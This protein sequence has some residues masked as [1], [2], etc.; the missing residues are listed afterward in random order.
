MKATTTPVSSSAGAQQPRQ[1]VG[2][3]HQDRA[4][5]QA[6][7][8]LPAQVG[9]ASRAP[10]GT[11]SPTKAIGPQPRRRRPAPP[12]TAGRPAGGG[13]RTAGRAPCRRPAPAGSAAAPAGQQQASGDMGRRGG[14]QGNGRPA[15]PPPRNGDVE[16]VAAQQGDGLHIGVQDGVDGGAGQDQ[17]HRHQSA[18]TRAQ[19]VHGGR[20]RQRAGQRGPERMGRQ[21]AR[22]QRQRDD[23]RAAPAFTPS[24]PGSA[25]GLRVSV[26]ISAPATAS[27]EPVR[28]AS[29]VRGT[30]ERPAPRGCRRAGSA[31]AIRRRAR[32]PWNPTR[33]CPAYRR[34][35]AGRRPSAP[36]ARAVMGRPCALC[37]PPRV[38]PVHHERDLRMPVH[39]GLACVPGR[40]QCGG[41]LRREP[42]SIHATASGAG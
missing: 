33:G 13:R 30:R 41:Q 21:A 19:P 31:R 4:K 28:K 34:P 36:S 38:R 11:A 15:S 37:R 3:Q 32:G 26:W 27:A 17:A 10:C 1:D 16:D 6:E 24:R 35:A 5:Q 14:G 7:R 12:C 29:S 18:S 9:P 22:D 20:G 8:Q 39:H 25:S 23:G 42:V 2:G 40:A